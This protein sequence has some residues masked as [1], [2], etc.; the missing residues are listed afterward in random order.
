M[1]RGQGKLGSAAIDLQKYDCDRLAEVTAQDPDHSFLPGAGL[2]DSESF[3]TDWKVSIEEILCFVFFYTNSDQKLS[4]MCEEKKVLRTWR[5]YDLNKY[6][7]KIN[8]F[9]YQSGYRYFKDAAAA[10]GL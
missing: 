3:P 7:F 4:N 2:A 8:L 5:Q 9:V 10:A 6:I 1:T